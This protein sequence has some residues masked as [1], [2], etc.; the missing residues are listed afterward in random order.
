MEKSS[1]RGRF[2]LG[3]IDITARGLLSSSACLAVIAVV[4]V[5][6]WFKSLYANS[7]WTVLNQLFVTVIS[8]LI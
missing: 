2:H 7:S 1:G 5:D 8:R 3:R 6:L 4:F